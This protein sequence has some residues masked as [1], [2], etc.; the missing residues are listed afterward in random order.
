MYVST[1]P[2]LT[3]LN[4]MSFPTLSPSSEHGTV[5]IGVSSDAAARN[6]WW[7]A[8]RQPGKIYYVGV[9]SEDQMASEF[10]FLSVF[11]SQPFSLLNNGVET[12]NGLLLPVNIPDGSPAHPGVG[13]IFALAVYPIDVGSVVVGDEIT[14][15]NFGDL[16]GTL[17]HNDISAV[18]NN[19]DSL[20]HPP[21]PYS[22]IYDDSGGNNFAGSQS[23]DGPGSL[24]NFIGTDG[25]GPWILTEVDD[26]L[27]QTGFV[28]NFQLTI[29]PHQANDTP[30]TNTV[31]G[32]GWFYDFVDVPPGA[33]NLTI[34]VTNIS[35]PLAPQ[36]LE[37]FVKYGTVPTT[38]NFDEMTLLLMWIR[39]G[40]TV[41][42]PSVR[43]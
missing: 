8:I 3:N 37:L 42:F 31:A 18:L 26:S 30:H 13:L 33:T 5:V 1:D 7:T 9:K 25:I 27:T 41:P 23:S 10:G 15:Q 11:T 16:I 14:H 28:S 24:K 38:N 20:G 34:S 21:G 12:V 22:F 17:N 39:L 40:W 35:T 4:T 6:S 43:R 32:L 2:A 19:H 36:P 29:Q